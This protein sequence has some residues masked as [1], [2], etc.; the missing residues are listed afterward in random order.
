MV[1]RL[2]HLPLMI[3]LSL[4]F[5]VIMCWHAWMHRCG[6]KCCENCH[7]EDYFLWPIGAQTENL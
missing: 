5:A 3:G 6:R 4:A 2:L 7:C 1:R